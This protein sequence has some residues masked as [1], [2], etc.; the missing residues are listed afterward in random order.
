[1]E[2]KRKK[3][4]KTKDTKINPKNKIRKTNIRAVEKS[5]RKG[6]TGYICRQS[7]APKIR[8]K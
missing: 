7:N 8:N 1:M 3:K 6:H 4:E 5:Q 2:R